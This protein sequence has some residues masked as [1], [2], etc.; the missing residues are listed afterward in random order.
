MLPHVRVNQTR[1]GAALCKCPPAAYRTGGPHM[2]V[3]WSF[4]MGGQE[5]LGRT[6]P[7][8]TGPQNVLS[9]SPFIICL[10][11]LVCPFAVCL[12]VV[13]LP[14][15]SSSTHPFPLLLPG[16]PLAAR[17]CSWGL[18]EQAEAKRGRVRKEVPTSFP[19]RHTGD[20]NR[21]QNMNSGRNLLHHTRL[22]DLY[23]KRHHQRSL[24]KKTH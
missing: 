13:Y 6:V 21:A 17:T 12:S 1:T 2:F 24:K 16:S 5:G 22:S 18:K 4:H 9:L 10:Y 19:S 11:L 3:L 20:Q 15:P 23:H 8:R 7:D 14:L